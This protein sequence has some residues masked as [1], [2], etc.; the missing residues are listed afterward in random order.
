MLT[1]L[2]NPMPMPRNIRPIISIVMFFAAAL[3]AA[4]ARNASAPTRIEAL[5]PLFLV[6]KEAPNVEISPAKYSEDVKSVSI[7]LSYLQ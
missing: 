3:R 7:W 2:P 4:P 1:W 5:L 6:T